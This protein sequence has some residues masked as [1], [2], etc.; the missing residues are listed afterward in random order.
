M[1]TA[2]E[3]VELV[4]TVDALEAAE[5]PVERCFDSKYAARSHLEAA[6]AA[7]GDSAADRVGDGG[8]DGGGEAVSDAKGRGAIEW[9]AYLGY[10]LGLNYLATE[11]RSEGE[12]KLLQAL[13]NGLTD[14]S[15]LA[16]LD[17]HNSLA[18]LYANRSEVEASE[19]HLT[20]AIELYQQMARP[21]PSV[22]PGV[23]D[24]DDGS[25]ASRFLEHLHTTSLFVLAQVAAAAG[26]VDESAQCCRVTLERQIAAVGDGG[27]PGEPWAWVANA[28]KLA[29]YY[30]T[31]GGFA[32]ARALLDSADIM[33]KRTEA[34]GPGTEAGIEARGDIYI[35]AASLVGDLLAAWASSTDGEYQTVDLFPQLAAS[36]ED[37]SVLSGLD[38]TPVAGFKA[39]Q[40][41]FLIGLRAVEAA[42]STFVLDGY[43]SKH[44]EAL[45]HKGRLYELLKRKVNALDPVMKELNYAHFY[46]AWLQLSYEV[47]SA[48]VG[49][50]DAK[51]AAVRDGRA[52]HTT[53]RLNEVAVKAI[54]SLTLYIAVA[55]GATP[56]SAESR[57]PGALDAA[58]LK[59][60]NEA[61]GNY[62]TARHMRGRL[63]TAL[64]AASDAATVENLDA[65]EAD[66]RAIKD[67]LELRG[68]EVDSEVVD[69]QLLGMTEEMLELIPQLKAAAADGQLQPR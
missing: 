11:E 26:R 1:A 8:H 29:G 60:D 64:R 63:Y 61:L 6:L 67:V 15:P 28:T 4:K 17:A 21:P 57:E 41:A 37:A 23:T 49:I 43:V 54:A 10:R 62:V 16:A 66:Y 22:I 32:T 39:A 42:L 53:Q 7:S 59:V 34:A 35:A 51:A 33:C 3:R 36:G 25:A 19:E 27:L 24:D 31:R 69:P 68:D 40:P 14:I 56:G 58:S 46:A 9:E 5:D 48:L 55:H 65:A 30:A 20:A 38:L 44:V 12:Q 45:I 18:V 50:Y 13:E 52:V 2:S 47:A